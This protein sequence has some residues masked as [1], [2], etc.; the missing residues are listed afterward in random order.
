MYTQTDRIEHEARL[1]SRHDREHIELE[2]QHFVD[3]YPV[4][5]YPLLLNRPS[6]TYPYHARPSGRTQVIFGII[7]A[8][9]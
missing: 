7:G 5:L 8:C 1:G 4:I 3:Y 9:Y 2:H 6:S